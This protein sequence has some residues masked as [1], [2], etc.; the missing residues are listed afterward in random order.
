MPGSSKTQ[1]QINRARTLLNTGHLADAIELADMLMI[2]APEKIEVKELTVDIALQQGDGTRAVKL[3]RDMIASSPSNYEYHGKAG[4][5]HALAGDLQTARN[6]LL[7][8]V[9]LN[10]DYLHAL[11]DLC[12]VARSLGYYDE[13]IKAGTAAL[14]IE[15]DSPLLHSNLALAYELYGLYHKARKHYAHA[16]MLC[17]GDAET[18]QK[19]GVACMFTGDKEE[20]RKYFEKAIAL[21]PRTSPAYRAIAVINKYDTTDHSDFA[22]SLIHI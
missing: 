21:N 4:V 22:L 13:S 6:H 19:A 10:P 2:I 8:A 18:Q 7:Q 9:R 20:A 11:L 14:E 15:P 16:A 12:K 17:P 1:R 3:L 5:A